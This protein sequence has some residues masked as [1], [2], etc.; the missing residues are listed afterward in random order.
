MGWVESISPT[1]SVSICLRHAPIG[2]FFNVNI[3]EIIPVAEDWSIPV[4]VIT[5]FSRLFP[6]QLINAQRG[7]FSI[8][9]QSKT[10]NLYQTFLHQSPLPI[11]TLPT[12][13]PSIDF[14]SPDPSIPLPFTSNK[15]LSFCL[16]LAAHSLPVNIKVPCYMCTSPLSRTL[17]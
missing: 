14:I 17:R 7:I 12:P 10:L 13:L 5:R 9:T 4:D 11:A 15:I 8:S 16:F 2:T 6:V 1:G 3:Q